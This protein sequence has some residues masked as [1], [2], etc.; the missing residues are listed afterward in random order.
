MLLSPMFFANPAIRLDLPCHLRRISSNTPP[1]PVRTPRR[2][3]PFR[4]IATSHNSRSVAPRSGV[5]PSPATK[6]CT[7]NCS[8]EHLKFMRSNSPG[9]NTCAKKG[10]GVD[11]RFQALTGVSTRAGSTKLRPRR[12]GPKATAKPNMMMVKI[13]NP[14]N[15]QP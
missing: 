6:A 10:E 11:R 1:R 13:S 9:M 5:A 12:S 3:H 8:Q 4:F 14:A 2:T 7:G 15:A